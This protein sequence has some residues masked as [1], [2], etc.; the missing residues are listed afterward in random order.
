MDEY[1]LFVLHVF[2]RS[3]RM[4][5]KKKGNIASQARTLTEPAITDL[6]YDLVDVEYKKEGQDWYLRF[7]ID[8]RGGISIDDC[9]TVTRAIDPIVDN[10]L[11]VPGYY[12]MEVSSPGLDRPLKTTADLI[13]YMDTEVEI[14]LYAP[15]EGNRKIT[16]YIM[17][18]DDETLALSAE[19]GHDDEGQVQDVSAAYE[20]KRSDVAK[21]SR[22]IRF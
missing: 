7:F 16:G 12:L 11:E 3:V 17:A 9:E 5:A 18:A 1:P 6:G 19:P 21:V 14:S 20:L 22:V 8:K 10:E 4:S 2:K 15:I 13:R